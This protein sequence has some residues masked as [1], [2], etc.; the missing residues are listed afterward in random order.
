MS[1][2]LQSLLLLAA[3]ALAGQPTWAAAVAMPDRYSAETA[4]TVIADGGNAVDAAIAAAFALAVTYPEAGNIGGG[5]FLVAHMEGTAA[6]LDFRE[7]APGKADRDMYLDEGGNFV[8]RSSLVGGRASGVPGTVRGLRAAHEK[9]GSLPWERLLAPAIKLARDGF[10]VHEDLSSFAREKVVEVGGETNFSDYFGQLEPGKMFRQ[11]ELAVTLARLS[12]DPDDFYTGETSKLLVAQML[13]S[14]GL[15]TTADLAAYRPVW[16]EPLIANWRDTTVITAPPPSSGG[17]ALLQL[18]AMRDYAQPLFADVWHNSPHYVHL[19]AEMEK[20]VFA[21]RAEYLGDPDFISNPVESL[22]DPAYLQRRAAEVNPDRISPAESVLPGLES[23]DTT[24]FSIIDAQGNAVSLTYTLNWDFGSGVVVEGAGFLM[25]NEMD[26]FSAKVG[27]RNEFGVIG[28]ENNA[29][30][31]NKR[32]LSSMTPTI[33][34]E[35]GKPALVLGTPGGS[36]IFTSVF[37]IILNV[38][39]YG[40][41]PQDAVNATRFHHQLPDATVIRHDQ[42]EIPTQTRTSLQRMGYE[43]VPNSWGNL[44]DVQLVQRQGDTLQAA[45]DGRGRGVAVVFD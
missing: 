3:L 2:V 16:R 35:D 18:L 30:V 14:D 21:D 37:Q 9:F 41:S 44:G 17:I 15:I 45:A 7:T 19:L 28:N 5:G 12:K 24:H 20:R 32:M 26:D 13:R 42:R 38:Y 6:F 40:M 36:T 22:I 31:P 27:V 34:L 33:V 4:K 23:P 25:N 1:R 43:V 39:D 10:V 11:P 8:Q 29:I